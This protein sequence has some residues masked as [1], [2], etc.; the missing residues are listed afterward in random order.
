MAPKKLAPQDF[1]IFIFM[2]PLTAPHLSG[3][4]A[5]RYHSDFILAFLM[6]TL[7]AV[8][9]RAADIQKERGV[10]L[11]PHRTALYP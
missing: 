2:S 5:L 7:T 11:P 9:K 10:R 8:L 3:I 4:V 1:Q 6:V